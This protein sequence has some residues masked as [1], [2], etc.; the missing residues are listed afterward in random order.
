MLSA[1]KISTLLVCE[2]MAFFAAILLAESGR[3]WLGFEYTTP[4]W[5]IEIPLF[6]Q[7]PGLYAMYCSGWGLAF[8]LCSITG[9]IGALRARKTIMLITLL[10]LLIGLLVFIGINARPAL[11]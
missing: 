5:G 7:T 8:L 6:Y 10:L 11:F 2:I 1:F 9:V 4:L 3:I